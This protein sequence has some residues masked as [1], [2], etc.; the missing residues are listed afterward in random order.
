MATTDVIRSQ[1]IDIASLDWAEMLP[2]VLARR[3]WADPDGSR[4]ALFIRFAPGAA[5]T[6]HA[7]RGDELAYVLEGT[8]VDDFSTIMPGTVGYRPDGCTHTVSSPTGATVFAVITGSIEGVESGA[9]GGPESRVFDL[10]S[11]GWSD[12]RPGVKAKPFFADRAAGRSASLVRFEAG[13]ELPAHRHEGSELVFVIEGTV[14][15]E[16]GA[17]RPGM[18]GFRPD[19]CAHT[20]RSPNGATALAFLWGGVAPI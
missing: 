8:V 4:V 16:A 6:R 10:P 9:T 18:L 15:D 11:M 12:L 20:V 3:V 17:V 14:E 13:A 1:L 7:H 19:G 5:L 2:G